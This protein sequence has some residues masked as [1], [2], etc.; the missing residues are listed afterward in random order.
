MPEARFNDS[1]ARK[2][3]NP[4]GATAVSPQLCRLRGGRATMAT[5]LVQYVLVDFV[6]GAPFAIS[7]QDCRFSWVGLAALSS[8]CVSCL[9][10]GVAA[11]ASPRPASSP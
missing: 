11:L 3:Q 10:V 7:A 6:W 4:G 1:R 8:I 2:A 5:S 9:R